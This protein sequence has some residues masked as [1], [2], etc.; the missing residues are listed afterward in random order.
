MVDGTEGP[1]LVVEDDDAIRNL[2]LEVLR[3]G[4]YDVVGAGNGA[5]GLDAV[6]HR[7]P[8]LILLDMRMPRMDGWTFARAYRATP[9]PHAPIIVCTAATD[10]QQRAAEIQAAGFLAKPFG[11]DELLATVERFTRRV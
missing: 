3:D 6:A 1:V 4:G 2:V 5:A 10:A 9:G 8:C 7:P 11:L